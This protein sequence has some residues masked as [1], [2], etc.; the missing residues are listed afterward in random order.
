MFSGIVES[1]DG[2][3]LDL[4]IAFV[5]AMIKF[6][7]AVFFTDFQKGS[8]GH[9]RRRCE[10]HHTAYKGRFS[11]RIVGSGTSGPGSM[12]PMSI[13]GSI[14]INCDNTLD[15]VLIYVEQYE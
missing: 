15:I 7:S 12:H 9:F 11:R 2:H 10:D 4:I 6:S 14:N 3:R 1:F 8:G 13:I 5:H